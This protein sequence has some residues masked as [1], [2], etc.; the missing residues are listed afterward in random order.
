MKS[1]I[2]IYPWYDEAEIRKCV[3]S[4][5]KKFD[6]SDEETITAIVD[7][8]TGD[9]TQISSLLKDNI[10]SVKKFNGEQS[11]FFSSSSINSS[12]R[13]KI[14][15]ELVPL[16]QDKILDFPY[17]YQFIP[18]DAVDV[19]FETLK[20]YPLNIIK[21]RIMPPNVHF[22]SK[23]DTGRFLFDIKSMFSIKSLENDYEKIDVAV[24][25][26][27]EKARLSAKRQDQ[28]MS[29]LER[30]ND[31]V[32]IREVLNNT[33]KMN[34]YSLRE[35]VYK[36]EKECTQFKPTL[37]YSIY[38]YFNARRAGD[39]SAG[40]GDRLFGAIAAGLE[41]YVGYDPNTSLREG[42]TDII[43]RYAKGKDFNVVYTGF[44][45]AVLQPNSFDIFFTSPPFFDFEIY[46]KDSTQSV[47]R[48]PK[49]DDWIVH[50]LF[51]SFRKAWDALKKEG[52][53]V[54][55]LTDVYK[56]KVC[57]KM[58]LLIQSCLHGALYIG[59]ITATGGEKP[60]PI[61]VFKKK[62]NNNKFMRQQSRREL[63]RLY[64]GVWSMVNPSEPVV[65][66]PPV[67]IRQYKC[68][69][70][71]LN[72]VD[73][74][75]LQAGTK[76]RALEAY[77]K[78]F[79]RGTTFVYA[80]PTTGIGQLALAYVA[81]KT[82][83]NS[84]LFL[85]GPANVEQVQRSEGYNADITFVKG[86]LETTQNEAKKWIVE[87]PSIPTHLIEFGI[88]EKKNESDKDGYASALSQAIKEAWGNN[89]HPGRLWIACGSTTTINALYKVFPKTQFFAVRVG[90][91]L[92]EDQFDMKRTTIVDYVEETG[93]KFSQPSKYRPNIR[94]I[95]EYDAKAIEF[96][97][98]HKLGRDQDYVWNVSG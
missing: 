75:V 43:N 29:I 4:T 34:P 13:E 22:L 76:Q 79:P 17:K 38:K 87:N 44:E 92:W 2:E 90:K 94:T 74:S 6:I 66:N 70:R 23:T 47:A 53:L 33:D 36:L 21:E 30:W 96:A 8:A 91:K 84:K 10:Y 82:G 1:L 14:I 85:H 63:K 54:I 60:R 81:N 78:T 37:A 19:M 95:R 71:T 7:S 12:D 88:S 68:N 25:V 16:Y 55:H 50:F 59:T 9:I 28:P 49:L 3:K 61:W 5:S 56:T 80:G 77:F 18:L 65:F 15:E 86:D 26:F 24:D 73:D 32:F 40:W 64:P 93:V 20:H 83:N 41:S 31:P 35:T 52:H 89:P 62:E 72:I 58:C 97:C 42:H 69:S 45:E 57:E 48:Y 98:F 39:I 46:S 51:A 27:Q 11:L 67:V